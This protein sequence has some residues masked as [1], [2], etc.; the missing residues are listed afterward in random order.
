MSYE[1]SCN[2]PLLLLTNLIGNTCL[3]LTHFTL[4]L[5]L[6]IKLRLI[7]WRLTTP[8]PCVIIQYRSRKIKSRFVY[9]RK[10]PPVLHTCAESR[11][12]FLDT[13]TTT[14]ENRIVYSLQ[15]RSERLR[16]SPVFLSFQID[17]FWL[18]QGPPL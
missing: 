1:G 10:V 12:E 4:F 8:D 6:P 9:K 16:C 5:K 11:T 7:I 2:S 15:F 17:S 14:K 3:P 13:G 18:S